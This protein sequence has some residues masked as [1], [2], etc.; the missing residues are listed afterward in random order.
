MAYA[1]EVLCVYDHVWTLNQWDLRLNNAGSKVELIDF[2]DAGQTF[3]IYSTTGE[4]SQ[5][6]L[7]RKVCME[8]VQ[9]I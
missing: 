4:V 3:F 5:W 6:H 7:G 1:D 9:K 8:I 2:A